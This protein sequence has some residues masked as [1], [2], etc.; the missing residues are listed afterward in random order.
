MHNK[1]TTP[2]FS[3]KSHFAFMRSRSK[4]LHSPLTH[5]FYSELLVL[6]AAVST[7]NNR[8]HSRKVRLRVAIT[9]ILYFGPSVRVTVEA[10]SDCDHDLG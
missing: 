4:C 2:K 3:S 5:R 6:E 10:K 7:G 1:K 8:L 9:M